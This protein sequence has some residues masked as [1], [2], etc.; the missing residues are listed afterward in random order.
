MPGNDT[1]FCAGLQSNTISMGNHLKIGNGIPPY[2]FRWECRDKVSPTLI[3]T[4]SDF[5]NDTAPANSPYFTGWPITQEWLK[6]IIHI[7]DSEGK[8]AKDSINVRFSSFA[9]LTGYMVKEVEKG[10]QCTFQPIDSIWR[11]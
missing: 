7:T 6:F 8:C 9:Y 3:F 1:T 10:G 11:Y 4:A 5:L 2:T